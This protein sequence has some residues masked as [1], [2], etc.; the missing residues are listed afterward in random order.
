MIGDD[1]PIDVE[2][3]LGGI[4]EPAWTRGAYQVALRCHAEKLVARCQ[5]LLM[6]LTATRLQVEVEA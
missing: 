1:A 4:L 5:K 2:I 3:E 6:R